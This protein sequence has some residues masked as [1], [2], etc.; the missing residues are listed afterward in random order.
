MT[1][2]HTLECQR[3]EVLSVYKAAAAL[4]ITNSSHDYQGTDGATEAN[5]VAAEGRICRIRC[6]GCHII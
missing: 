4:Y 3:E 2:D 6:A 5:G 1:K